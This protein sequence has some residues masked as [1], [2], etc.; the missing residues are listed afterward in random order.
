MK[1]IAY[2]ISA[3]TDAPHLN[4]LIQALPS[5][6]EFFIHVDVKADINTFKRCVTNSHAHFI[7]DRINVMWGSFGQVRYQMAL[8]KAA[9]AFPEPFDYLF[10]ISGLDYPL[11]SNDKIMRYIDSAQGKNFLRATCLTNNKED[12]RLYREYRF[13]NTKP[14][15][16]G[17]IKSKFR[18][19]IRKILTGMNIHKPLTVPLGNRRV[20][21]YKGGSWWG[22]TRELAQYALSIYEKHPE[23]TN[24]FK[25][26][27]G[28]DET[29][30]HTIA[31]NSKF[32]KYCKLIEGKELELEELSP[33]TYI[34]YGEEIK[35]F[36]E[37]D[38]KT[39][40]DSGKMFCRK[41]KTGESDKLLDKIDIY[42]K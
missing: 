4:R 9:L 18:V 5:N 10:S 24:Y 29:F 6:A 35:V 40:I 41:T 30:I 38:F 31:L 11:W 12:A 26:S 28:P 37:E 21:L 39:L 15:K 3:H 16:Y 13:L 32:A 42:R 14:W 27:F 20:P 1:R 33:L 22:I 34:E 25:T 36:Q 19:A 7:E 8:I 2:L 17:T 23:F